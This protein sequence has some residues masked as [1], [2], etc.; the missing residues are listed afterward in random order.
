MSCIAD[1]TACVDGIGFISKSC[2]PLLASCQERLQE[3]T[4]E[5]QSSIRKRIKSLQNRFVQEEECKVVKEELAKG[6]QE[7]NLDV[8]PVWCGAGV[9]LIHS[10]DTAEDVVT[11]TW[12]EASER[13]ALSYKWV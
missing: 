5:A 4:S 9:G 10:I 12:E 2:R 3:G 8:M 1:A 7:G 6:M 11:K 13:I